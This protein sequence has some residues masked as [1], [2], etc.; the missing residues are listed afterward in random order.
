MI[1]AGGAGGPPSAVVT[2]RLPIPPSFITLSDEHRPNA[3]IRT[4][5]ES[6]S[7][8]AARV[9]LTAVRYKNMSSAVR[10]PHGPTTIREP[11]DRVR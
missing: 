2:A 4:A 10:G 6:A 1:G 7:G 9:M 3:T 8:A 11:M 5:D